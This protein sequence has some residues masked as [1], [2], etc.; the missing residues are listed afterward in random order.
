MINASQILDWI[1]VKKIKLQ[2]TWKGLQTAQMSAFA[3][4][5]NIFFYD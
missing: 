3:A 5:I 4:L 1:C 2:I